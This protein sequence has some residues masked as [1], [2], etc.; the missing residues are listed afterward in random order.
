MIKMSI[1]KDIRRELGIKESRKP[2]F[3]SVEVDAICNLLNKS[4]DLSV[5]TTKRFSKNLSFWK[6]QSTVETHASIDNLQSILKH[7]RLLKKSSGSRNLCS[8]IQ[9]MP[10]SVLDG[11]KSISF[12]NNKLTIQFKNH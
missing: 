3:S 7:I 2:Y 11:V 6:T 5:I 10:S 1:L 4:A 12:T 9:E 8:I